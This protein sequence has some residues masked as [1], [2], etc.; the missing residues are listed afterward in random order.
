MPNGEPKD[1][2]L[3]HDDT[4]PSRDRRAAAGGH[5]VAAACGKK[6]TQQTLIFNLKYKTEESIYPKGKIWLENDPSYLHRGTTWEL[7]IYA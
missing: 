4:G 2:V 1:E 5:A 3:G 6:G 7:K